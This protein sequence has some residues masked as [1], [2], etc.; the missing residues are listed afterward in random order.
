[1]KLW[2]LRA[3]AAPRWLAVAV[4]A[5]QLGWALLRWLAAHPGVLG[6]LTVLGVIAWAVRDDWWPWL[7]LACGLAL[8]GAGVGM[9]LQA[10]WWQ[11]LSGAWASHRRLRWYRKRWE[12]AMIGA[13]LTLG[14]DLPL[15]VSHRFG[16]LHGER[17]LDVLTVQTVPGQV[18]EDWRAVSPRLAAAWG[19]T[20]VRAH[21]LRTGDMRAPRSLEL[22]C[23][24]QPLAAA[25]RIA[26]AGGQVPPSTAVEQPVDRPGAFPR[27][28]R[29]ER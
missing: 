21:Q 11:K 2:S 18:L 6:Y 5:G 13:G 20:R 24:S 19:R 1:M 8:I 12:P 4:W 29:G 16:G 28:P 17:D 9:E 10:A 15:L 7:L 27:A 26:V 22:F 23:S 14:D 25:R 3:P